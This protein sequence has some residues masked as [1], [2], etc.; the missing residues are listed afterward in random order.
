MPANRAPA[1]IPAT[2]SVEQLLQEALPRPFPAYVL[3]LIMPSAG[4]SA[5][6]PV[7]GVTALIELKCVA[8]ACA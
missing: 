7:H 2:Q 8:T 4:L 6:V 5:C 1:M 3:K